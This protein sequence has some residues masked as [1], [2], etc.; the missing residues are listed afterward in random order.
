MNDAEFLSPAEAAGKLGIHLITVYRWV[1]SGRLKAKKLVNRQ[2]R[3]AAKE[4]DRLL[5]KPVAKV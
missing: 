3:I 4:V 5:N 2:L 1:A